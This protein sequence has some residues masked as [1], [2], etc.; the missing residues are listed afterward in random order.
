MHFHKQN[1]SYQKIKKKKTSTQKLTIQKHHE[2]I[3][4]T[5]QKPYHI[6]HRD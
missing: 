3:N 6:S 1:T 4:F 5:I 2:H